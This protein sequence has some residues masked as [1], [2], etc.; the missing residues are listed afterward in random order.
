MLIVSTTKRVE[1]SNPQIKIP[2]N[3]TDSL[4]NEPGVCSYGSKE[5]RQHSCK[6]YNSCEVAASV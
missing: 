6:K 4:I 2:N 5:K 3:S 1:S